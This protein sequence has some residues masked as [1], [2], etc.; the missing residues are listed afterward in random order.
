VQEKGEELQRQI[1]GTV[2]VV[3]V[4]FLMRVAFSIMFA[5]IGMGVM[6]AVALL[7]DWCSRDHSAVALV[8]KKKP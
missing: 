5:L 4:S 3:F 7:L 6:A 1:L 2:V 8:T